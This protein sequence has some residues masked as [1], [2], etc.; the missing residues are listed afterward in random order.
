MEMS[1]TLFLAVILV[2]LGIA[3]GVEAK[4]V[5]VYHNGP[6]VSKV[7]DLPAETIVEDLH[8][9]LGVMYDQF[10]LFWLPVW[11]YGEPKYVLIDDAEETYWDLSSDDLNFIKEEYNVEIEDTPTIP[12]WTQVGLKPVIAGLLG[13]IVWGQFRKKEEK[14]DN[15]EIEEEVDEEEEEA[16]K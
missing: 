11:N 1:K 12:F 3:Q 7:V 6:T 15:E 10:G 4:G 2:C 5:I 13:F 16:I 8:V 14:E 9:N